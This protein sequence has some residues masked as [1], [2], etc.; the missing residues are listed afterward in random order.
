MGKTAFRALTA[1]IIGIGIVLALFSLQGWLRA[2]LVLFNSVLWF[3]LVKLW[4]RQDGLDEL[5][6]NVIECTD[7]TRYG[8]VAWLWGY[9]QCTGRQVREMNEW[10]MTHDFAQVPRPDRPQSVNALADVLQY[11]Q[12]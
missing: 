6:D 4:W 11:I 9:D 3:V 8:E 1:I 2:L 12:R 10:L 5:R 7:S